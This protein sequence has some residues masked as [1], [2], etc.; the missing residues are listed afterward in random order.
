MCARQTIDYSK[1]GFPGIWGID[2]T[3]F[4]VYT[5]EIEAL[6]IINQLYFRDPISYTPIPRLCVPDSFRGN[7][8]DFVEKAYKEYANFYNTLEEHGLE[9]CRQLGIEPMNKLY[10]CK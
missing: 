10:W 9:K 1:K 4:E 8:A 6:F 5:L 2:S 7:Y 3:W